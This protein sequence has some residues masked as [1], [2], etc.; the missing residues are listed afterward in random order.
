VIASSSSGGALDRYGTL[1]GDRVYTIYLPTSPGLVVMEYSDRPSASSGQNFEAEL[2]APEPVKVDLPEELQRER[3]VVACVVD[4]EGVIRNV[5]V[6]EALVAPLTDKL[7]RA[8]AEWRFRPA[9]RGDEPIE[10]DALLG[11]Q[12]DTR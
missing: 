4:R 6:L 2:T 5:R 7:L 10:V 3:I 12:I 9:L 1:K 11:F 8:L